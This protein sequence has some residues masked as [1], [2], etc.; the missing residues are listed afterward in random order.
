M[1]ATLPIYKSL[2]SQEE[3]GTLVAEEDNGFLVTFNKDVNVTREQFFTMF[4]CACRI[5]EW[6]AHNT[7][8]Q[9]IRQAKIM[10]FELEPL[11]L[12]RVWSGVESYEKPKG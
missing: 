12:R 10:A 7:G 8:Q 2:E 1:T 5:L 4:G 9:I 3:I 6:E 11:K